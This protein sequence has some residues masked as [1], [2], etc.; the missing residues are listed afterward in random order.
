MATVLVLSLAFADDP[1]VDTTVVAALDFAAG[2]LGEPYLWGGT[3]DGG[4]DCSGLSQAAYAHAGVHIPRVAQDQFDAGPPVA[5][6]TVVPGDLLFFGTGP[7]GVDHVGIYAGDGLMVDAPHTGAVVRVETAD[8]S[9]LVGA[10]R[11][12]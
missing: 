1:T 11:P 9:D 2:Q 5:T 4:F 12:G 7:T 6:G 3:G 8:W 10:T